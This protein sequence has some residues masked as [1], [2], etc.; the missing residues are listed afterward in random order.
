[1]RFSL[2]LLAPLFV[3]ACGS[4]S[5][6]GPEPAGP[7]PAPPEITPP[8]PP[9]PPP[10]C[11]EG[12]TFKTFAGKIVVD[13]SLDGGKAQPWVLDTGAFTSAI[14]DSLAA[15]YRGK[16]VKLSVAGV[17]RSLILDTG[18][19]K[20]GLRQDIVG[21]LGQDVFGSALT[22]DYPRSRL[23]IA[24]GVDEAALKA[25]DHVKGA[26]ATVDM[27]QDIYLYVQGNAEGTPGWF[28]VDSGASI[29]ATR[30]GFF[31]R[32]NTAHPR[33]SVPG[34]YT[35]AMIGTFWADASTIG[36]FEVGGQRVEHIPTRTVDDKLLDPPKGVSRDDFVG[37]LPSG[38][39]H[40]FMVT[41][42]F[43]N[44]K[45]RLDAPKDGALREPAL[46]FPTGI[47]LEAVTTGPVHVA[48]VLPGSSAAE[49]G[50]QVGDEIVSISG[51]DIASID[52]YSRAFYF[53]PT[54]DKAQI[55]CVLKRG[56]VETPYTLE[57][58][59]LLTAP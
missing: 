38:F 25:C 45:L 36:S 40:H 8:D 34:F 41:I 56:D 35:P 29:G 58:R 21:I 48:S 54:Q 23:W 52:L 46:F 24:D 17:D 43:K 20:Q 55:Q 2:A 42:D 59:D 12:A 6:P 10:T 44:S 18:P 30:K 19:V 4:S 37:C 15:Q 14:D 7:A 9:A 49:Q 5:S 31:D 26:P 28:L 50:V 27:V 13:V 16:E 51:T 22:L 39:L 1:M 32:L 33:P 11:P 53:S 57:A 47:G 3:L